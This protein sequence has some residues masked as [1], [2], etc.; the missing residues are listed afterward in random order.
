M[1]RAPT[2]KTGQ[3]AAPH[4]SARQHVTGRALYVDDVPLPDKTLHVATGQ[5]TCAHG[6]I[7]RL[8][9]TRVRAAPGVVDVITA[10][11]VP[12]DIDIGP[13][14]PG[15]P[16]LADGLVEYIGQPIFAVAA[17]SQAAALRAAAL[18]VVEYDE[19]P[20]VLTVEAALEQ[21]NFVLPTRDWR[22]NDPD[23]AL[24]AAAHRVDSALYVRGQ[25]HF[26]LEGQAA[27]AAPL[28]DGMFVSTATQ[29]PS[30]VQKLVA[31]VLG[32]QLHHVQVEC[33][34][35]GGGFGGKESQAAPLAC[36]AAV[37]AHRNGCHVKYRMPRKDDMVQTGK[38]HD[39]DFQSK[40]GFDEDGRITGGNFQIAGKCGFSPD[41]SEG[42]VDRAMFHIDNAYF[43]PASHILGYACKTNTVSNTAFRGFG[44]PQGM[45]AIES[46]MDEAA[47]ALG[48]EPLELRKRNLY[49]PG[50]D[51]TPYG[52]QIDQFVLPDLISQLEQQAD[53]Q[54]R[55]EAIKAANRT[56]TDTRR[57]IALTPVKF[58]ISFTTTHL[59]QAGALVHVYTDGSIEVS[60]GGTEMGQG[61]YTKVAQIVARAF[62]VPLEQ[63]RNSA[64]RT[65]KVPNTSPTAASA[66]ADMNGFAAANACERIK[67][68][69]NEFAAEHKDHD[70]DLRFAN[71]S[72]I[73]SDGSWQEPFAAFVKA[74]YL[75][76]TPLSATGFYATPGIHMD[77]QRGQGN[78]FYYFANGAAVSE[79]E[80]DVW[81]GAYRVTRVD[82]LHDVGDSLNPAIDLGQIEGGFIQGMGWLT[83][84][85]LLWD[86]SGRVIANSPANYKIPAAA[87]CPPEFNVAFYDAP[88]TKPTIHRSKAVGE[89]PVNLAISVWCALRDAC[90][91]LSD[92]RYLPPLGVPATAE[93]VYFAAE[94][95]RLHGE[96]DA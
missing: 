27:Y 15:D 58:G 64:T 82:I 92:Y 53:F 71:G 28:D 36:M 31:K 80:I 7:T 6:D 5:S 46:A 14:F 70:G 29:H 8:D 2:D 40:L 91:S 48:L 41:L 44:G 59:N 3:H 81:S 39:F 68:A 25:E 17:T 96:A 16:L 23:A 38:R 45:L 76:R 13:V 50:H 57:G 43:I 69:L 55:R 86:D 32:V 93:Q 47:Y 61:L 56:S 4:E 34:R 88:N 74:A 11:D 18:A 63:V 65:D 85:E 94:K 35:M 10:A 75:A 49:R 54:A 24:A 51:V 83:T 87:D 26:Y 9:L 95:A 42:I 62:G 77:K 67:A 89:P 33:R 21:E 90:A 79:V 12:G 19:R 66:S 84:E 78:P 22:Q 37:F 73:A 30:E 20:P 1:N 72:V 52:Q 60:H